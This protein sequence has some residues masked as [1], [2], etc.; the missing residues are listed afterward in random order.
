MRAWIG[1]FQRMDYCG[2]IDPSPVLE[3]LLFQFGEAK[4]DV[5]THGKNR[6][7]IGFAVIPNVVCFVEF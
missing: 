2:F 6:R 1:S 3:I 7:F 5:V 4:K